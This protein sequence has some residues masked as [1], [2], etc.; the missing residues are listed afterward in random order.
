M[1]I[2][3]V[4]LTSLIS[5]GVSAQIAGAARVA[6]FRSL[7]SDE[8]KVEPSILY[9]KT[10]AI[11]RG[12]NLEWKLV[13]DATPISQRQPSAPDGTDTSSAM[14]PGF[15]FDPY[16]AYTTTDAQVVGEAPP[17]GLEHWIG[18]IGICL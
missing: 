14:Q 12:T 18:P 13:F 2:L 6:E 1:R 9:Q 3:F 11:R 10:Q 15:Y 8:L 17:V 5:V 4:I 16:S 7:P